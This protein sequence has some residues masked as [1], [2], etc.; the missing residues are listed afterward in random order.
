MYGGLIV[1]GFASAETAMDEC[2]GGG[3]MS[4]NEQLDRVSV[5]HLILQERVARDTGR[6]DQMRACYAGDSTV[7]ISWFRGSGFDFVRQGRGRE[8]VRQR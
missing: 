7:D 1:G 2:L 6:W 8:V 4:D 3:D 5:S